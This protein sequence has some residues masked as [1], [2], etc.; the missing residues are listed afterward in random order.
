MIGRCPRRLVV[1]LCAAL[2]LHSSS[3]AE[4][5]AAPK[6]E[7]DPK[8]IALLKTACAHIRGAKSFT[9]ACH[10]TRLMG[11]RDKGDVL[12]L[13]A[14]MTYRA[15]RELRVVCEPPKFFQ[16]GKPI[17]NP[18]LSVTDIYCNGKKVD[19]VMPDQNKYVR[20][21]APES[22]MKIFETGLM[23]PG[24]NFPGMTAFPAFVYDDPYKLMT[25]GGRITVY[26]GTETLDGAKCHV[27]R[28]M[29][30]DP[31]N[32]IHLK[33]WIEV[34]RPVFR[35][36]MTDFSFAEIKG[37]Q[38]MEPEIR[39]HFGDWKINAEVADADFAYEPPA[40]FQKV[41]TFM[42]DALPTIDAP[43]TTQP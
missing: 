28:Q 21:D 23:P 24:G 1:A 25:A 19:F 18:G 8:A 42:I 39:I 11:T 26:E 38:V 12:E 15:P 34:D 27:L 37:M 41:D 36:F 35:Q 5:S 6:R 32:W 2:V 20:A 3:F 17:E 4:D 43:P 40:A 33:V 14:K 10:L 22:V 9:T 13:R 16:A 7:S 29:P 31:E 30:A